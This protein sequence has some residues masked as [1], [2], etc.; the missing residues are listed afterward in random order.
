MGSARVLHR[1]TRT[2]H[3]HGLHRVVYGLFWGIGAS[4]SVGFRVLGLGFR[5][6]G[7]LRV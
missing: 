2:R 6:G 7:L 3:V 1:R 5:V 4:G